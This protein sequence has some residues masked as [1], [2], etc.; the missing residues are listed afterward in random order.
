MFYFCCSFLLSDDVGMGYDVI[1]LLMYP[2]FFRTFVI[3]VGHKV[4][5]YIGLLD[6]KDPRI[7][8]PNVIRLHGIRLVASFN[9]FSQIMKSLS[10]QKIVI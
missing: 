5:N 6:F 1:L 8:Q 10:I 9:K 4:T 2:L 3:I 7:L